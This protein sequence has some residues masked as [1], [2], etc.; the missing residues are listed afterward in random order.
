MPKPVALTPALVEAPQV[1]PQAATSART[2]MATTDKPPA[3]KVD[4]MPLQVRLP[5]DQVKA[6]KIAAAEREQPRPPPSP[7]T[8]P[9]RATSAARR[10]DPFIVRRPPPGE[11]ACSLCGGIMKIRTARRGRQA[12]S[13]FLGCVR[14]PYCTG[15]QDISPDQP[16]KE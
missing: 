16:H 10:R 9:P 4:H 15:T 11:P 3:S 5:R 2:G 1:T 6:I 8:P 7:L 13:Q 12:G 14:Y